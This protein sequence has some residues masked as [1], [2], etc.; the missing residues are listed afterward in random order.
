MT[1]SWS[2]DLDKVR[3]GVTKMTCFSDV[4]AAQSFSRCPPGLE[5]I[6][7][8]FKIF[9]IFPCCGQEME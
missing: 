1:T 6:Y 9:V 7:D 3:A 2:R 5:N 8:V 4:R